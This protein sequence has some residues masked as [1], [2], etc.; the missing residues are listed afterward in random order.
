[1]VD[2]WSQWDIDD[3]AVNTFGDDRT[4]AGAAGKR[5]TYERLVA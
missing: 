3:W 1:M 5:L 4:I 2:N